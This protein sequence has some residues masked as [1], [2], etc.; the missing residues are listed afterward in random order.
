MKSKQITLRGKELIIGHG[1]TPYK[2]NGDAYIVEKL[3]NS[4]VKAYYQ[5]EFSLNGYAKE[6]TATWHE[7]TVLPT[8]ELKAFPEYFN[9][10]GPVEGLEMIYLK[11]HPS[12]SYGLIPGTSLHKYDYY[13]AMSTVAGDTMHGMIFRTCLGIFFEI[14]YGIKCMNNQGELIQPVTFDASANKVE[15][16]VTITVTPIDGIVPFSYSLDA[17][18]WQSSNVFNLTSTEESPITSVTVF[19]KDSQE[20]IANSNLLINDSTTTSPQ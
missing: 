9:E 2:V 8:T 7:V 15:E 16:D 5:N 11:R 14:T 19:V 20:T 10:A 12:I 6:V 17:I 4:K 3:P 13:S 18:T 1:I